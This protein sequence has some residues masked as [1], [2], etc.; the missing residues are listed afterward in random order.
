MKI[1]KLESHLIFY[2]LPLFARA[3]RAW[4]MRLCG[5]TAPLILIALNVVRLRTDSPL[6]WWISI[7]AT[8][9]AVGSLVFVV[10]EN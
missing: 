10:L 4:L 3:D 6:E 8:L 7:P 9:A 1:V 5:L 2:V